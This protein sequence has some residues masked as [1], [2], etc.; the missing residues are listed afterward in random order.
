LGAG[1]AARAVKTTVEHAITARFKKTSLSPLQKRFRQRLL[2]A[3]KSTVIKLAAQEAESP[4]PA[5]QQRPASGSR[6]SALNE[7]IELATA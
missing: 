1:F 3:L 5:A 7:L 2:Y 4:I 6:P